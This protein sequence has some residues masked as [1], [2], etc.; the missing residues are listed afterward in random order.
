MIYTIDLEDWYKIVDDIQQDDMDFILHY[1][2]DMP[3]IGLEFA[4]EQDQ[5]YFI[6]KYVP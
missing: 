4:C 1:A 3:F 6:L 5:M 2:D